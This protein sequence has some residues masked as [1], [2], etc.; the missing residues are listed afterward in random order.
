MWEFIRERHEAVPDHGQ[1][2]LVRMRATLLY[3]S[4]HLPLYNQDSIEETVQDTAMEW[5][6]CEKLTV[7]S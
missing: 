6:I 7:E 2:L 3:R 4:A 1:W 5:D